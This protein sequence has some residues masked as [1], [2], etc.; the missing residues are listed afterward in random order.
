MKK[1]SILLAGTLLVAFAWAC[2]GTP[3]PGEAS[4]PFNL[5]GEY[6]GQLS[7]DGMAFPTEVEIE[8]G[9]GGELRG[10]YHVTD[11]VSMEG[12][13]TGSIVGDTVRFD[14]RYTNP[15]DGC[16]GTLGATGTVEEGGS[17]FAGRVRV[18][19]SCGGSLSGRFSFKR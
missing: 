14:L 11:P 19:D 15:M 6:A 16:G 9:T 2:A 3:G 8:T 4:Y 1:S 10:T 12:G 5:S 7:V 13:I 18:D 17:A